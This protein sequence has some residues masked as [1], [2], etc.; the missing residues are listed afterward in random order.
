M[1]NLVIL[2]S[3]DITKNIYNIPTNNECKSSEAGLKVLHIALK[4]S[5]NEIQLTVYLMKISLVQTLPSKR[6]LDP[7]QAPAYNIKQHRKIKPSC[8]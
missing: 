2:L 4:L 3:R 5:L 6:K 7:F 8:L 1:K